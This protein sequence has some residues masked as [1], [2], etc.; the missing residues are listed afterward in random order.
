[1]NTS[2]QNQPVNTP[3]LFNYNT[4]SVLYEKLNGKITILKGTVFHSAFPD[5]PVEQVGRFSDNGAAVICLLKAG[6]RYDADGPDI[7]GIRVSMVK[8]V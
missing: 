7:S 8:F 6:W 1:M 3:A 4:D 5:K 2:T